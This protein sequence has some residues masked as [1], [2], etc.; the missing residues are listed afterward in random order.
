MS[1]SSAP[2]RSVLNPQQFRRLGPLG[3]II[4]LHVGFFYALQSGLLRQAAQATLPKEVFASFITPEKPPQPEPPRP[5]P[6]TVPVV[7]KPAT[8]PAITPVVKAPSESAIS[9][10]PPPTQPAAA[11]PVAVVP[12]PAPPAPPAPAPAAPIKT[13]SS[14][15]EYLQPP[16]PVYPQVS[17]R[18]GEE[19]KVV[20]RILINESGRPDRVDVQTSSGSPRLDEAARQAALRALFKP[21]MADGKATAVYAIVPIN[22]Q[23]DR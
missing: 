12:A 21:H 14:G 3:L 7:R 17:K 22:F 16:Q 10:P 13:I 8:Q 9:A 19:G 2:L 18:L 4:L 6:K 5:Q 23:L 11:E 15:V 1:P 20:L